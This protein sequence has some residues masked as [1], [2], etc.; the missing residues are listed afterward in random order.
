V[1]ER[2]GDA[3]AARRG[4]DLLVADRSSLFLGLEAE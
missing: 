2:V 4:V 3:R 1:S